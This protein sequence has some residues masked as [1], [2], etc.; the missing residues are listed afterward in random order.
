MPVLAALLVALLALL[1]WPGAGASPAFGPNVYLHAAAHPLHLSPN[2][3]TV[4][5]TAPGEPS[6]VSVRSAAT[7]ITHLR[8][9]DPLHPVA[10]VRWGSFLQD[11][12][13]R[14]HSS[15]RRGN[16]DTLPIMYL[17]Q[18]GP[19]LKPVLVE[20]SPL[21]VALFDQST[22]H[23][24]PQADSRLL[25][26]IAVAASQALLLGVA[27]PSAGPHDVFLAR[28]S[29]G[30]L[31]VLP[32]HLIEPLLGSVVLAAPGPGPT[33]FLASGTCVMLLRHDM[34]EAVAISQMHMSGLVSQMLASRIVSSA[35]DCPASSDLVL[36]EDEARLV[37]LTCFLTDKQRIL[38]LGL[39]PGASG[40]GRLL[41]PPA[42]AMHDAFPRIFYV[43]APSAPGPGA[44]GTLWQGDIDALVGVTWRRV[45]PPRSVPDFERLDLLRLRTSGTGP[46]RW[47]L[48]A[49]NVALFDSQAFGCHADPSIVCD[50]DGMDSGQPRGWACAPGQA[51]SPFVSPDQLCAGCREGFYLDR[52]VGE[53]PFADSR[54]TCR[55][56]RQADCRVCNAQH[57]LMCAEGLLLEPSGPDGQTACVASCSSGFTQGTNACHPVDDI[58]PPVF[59]SQPAAEQLPGLPAGAQVTG[60]GETRL[61]LD[62]GSQLPRLTSPP[63]RLPPLGQGVLLFT[64]TH[65][66]LLLPGQ[67]IGNPYK[68]ALRPMHLLRDPLPHAVT[69]MIEVG[70]FWHEGM[71]LA[72]QVLC[73]AGGTISEVWLEC[74]PPAGEPLSC[75]V[76][77]PASAKA[78]NTDRCRDLRRL[79]AQHVAISLDGASVM[80]LRAAPELRRFEVTWHSAN[81]MVLLPGMAAGRSSIPGPAGDWMILALG[82]DRTS[83]ILRAMDHTDSRVDMYSG[84]LL[85]NYRWNTEVFPVLLPCGGARAPEL[86]LA[87]TLDYHW[88]VLHLPGDMLPSGRSANLLATRLDLGRIPYDLG[89]GLAEARFQAL[90]LEATGPEYPSALLM[91][92]GHVLGVSL[93]RCTGGPAGPCTLLPAIFRLLPEHLRLAPGDQLW[94]Q[95]VARASGRDSLH[96]DPGTAMAMVFLS[97]TAGLVE[98]S[99]AGN[100]LHGT[101]GLECRACDPVCLGCYDSGPHSCTMCRARMPEAPDVCLSACPAGLHRDSSSMCGCHSSCQACGFQPEHGAYLCSRCRAGFARD[102]GQPASDRCHPCHESCAACVVPGDMGACTSCPAGRWLFYGTCGL[103]CP[104]GT[105]PDPASRQCVPCPANCQ[106]CSQD[107]S[108]A[109]CRQ[110]F[111]RHSDAGLCQACHPSCAA[112]DNATSCAACR[113]GLVFLAT[114]AGQASLPCG[115]RCAS[116]P[117]QPATCALCERGWLLASPD[118][119]AECP[120]GSSSLGGLCSAC[121]GTCATCHGPGPEHCLTCKPDTPLSM[122][123]RCYAAC[124]DGTFQLNGS[125]APCSAFC[126]T[127]TGP[128]STQC[129]GCPEG[130]V[131]YDGACLGACPGGFYAEAGACHRCQAPCTTC[132]GPGACTGCRPGDFLDP[133][134]GCGADCPAGWH[135]CPSSGRCMACGGN[136][137]A[138]QTVGADCAARCSACEGGHVLSDGRCHR[139][140]PA[141]EYAPEGSGSCHACDVSCTTCAQRADRCT[142]C[143]AG[144]L[145]VDTGLCVGSCPGH[146]APFEGVCLS[147]A[148]GC[149][150]CAAGRAQAGC[151]VQADGQLLCPEMQRCLACEPGL[152]LLDGALCVGECPRGTFAADADAA[153]PAC[154]HCHAK[155]ATC[156]GPG[157]RDC[158]QSPGSPSSRVGLAVGLSMGLVLLLGLVIVA[159]VFLVRHRQRPGPAAPKDLDAED[160]TML[161]TIVELAL[162]GAILVAPTGRR[163][164][165]AP[166]PS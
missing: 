49:A 150:R 131:V 47:T 37:L 96:D 68:P 91:M 144:V 121:H 17:P 123:G 45:V 157:P 126:G 5:H 1:P 117:D 114:D 12:G 27:G 3:R 16:P 130:R 138:C 166:C 146:T 53:P 54:H 124:P 67:H 142:G 145:V 19:G 25:A 41:G 51:E 92:T 46:G 60:I 2:S 135:G 93:L 158:T 76:P 164:S 137:A 128:G 119:V 149:D 73:N 33:F 129:T 104:E 154:E 141:G 85:A 35:D 125:C 127:C 80:L 75:L 139:A 20:Y 79:D 71:L 84:R 163:S 105:W 151:E 89:P 23:P 22:E 109:A 63:A 69:A 58:L 133:A 107:N 111:F 120:A 161:N 140:C 42:R 115:S 87:Q 6:Q 90:P 24:F 40:Q 118:C 30:G 143:P 13:L 103:A 122:N 148:A 83:A 34:P 38:Q 31:E 86:F 95:A 50:G 4:S 165:S 39:P 62:P 88:H 14:Y 82:Q 81:A 153:V 55:P 160:A 15:P 52:P 132:A 97:P 57:C 56:C 116:C 101:Y 64:S 48:A 156:H 21:W 44:S 11:I 10:E 29:A 134:G 72:G 61:T 106:A 108:C 159:V 152:L 162:P 9:V 65:E 100:C 102:P 78:L 28:L 43:D 112:C 26:G 59:L 36:M 98:F 7:L 110:G 74:T 136:C 99:L 77:G 155:C 113:P 8:Q 147:C 66:S 32:V 94:Q 18:E 70:P